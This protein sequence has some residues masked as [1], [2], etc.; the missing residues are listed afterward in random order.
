MKEWISQV[1][2][3]CYIDKKAIKNSTNFSKEENE[4]I[5]P[6]NK[7]LESILDNI[8]LQTIREIEAGGRWK[9]TPEVRKIESLI[10]QAYKDAVNGLQTID[11]FRK[12][13]DQWRI[14]GLKGDG[15][16]QER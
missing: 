8:I 16:G 14:T 12:I 10:D 4:V 7:D 15:L 13:C 9:I 6:G 3:E 2:T 11:Y 1:N 5:F